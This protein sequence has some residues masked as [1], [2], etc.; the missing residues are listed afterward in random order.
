MQVGCQYQFKDE[1]TV[2]KY[3]IQIKVI[4]KAKF[5]SKENQRLNIKN[6]ITK[7]KV[8]PK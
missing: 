8:K 5:Q 2:F 3:H 4:L 7:R 1:N 6:K